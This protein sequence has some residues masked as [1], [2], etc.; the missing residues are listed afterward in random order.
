MKCLKWR[1]WREWWQ[2]HRLQITLIKLVYYVVLKLLKTF[3]QNNNKVG[4]RKMKYTLRNQLSIVRVSWISSKQKINSHSRKLWAMKRISKRAINFLTW[5]L[6]LYSNCSFQ[7]IFFFIFQVNRIASCTV[8]SIFSD[9]C[10][11]ECICQLGKTY[12][13]KWLV[14]LLDICKSN[15]QKSFEF[16]SLQ[17]LFSL[18]VRKRC[19]WGVLKRRHRHFIYQIYIIPRWFYCAHRIWH[20][21]TNRQMFIENLMQ[22]LRFAESNERKNGWKSFLS[23][24]SFVYSFFA[25]K[26]RREINVIT[27]IEHGERVLFLLLNVGNIMKVQQLQVVHLTFQSALM[28]T[29]KFQNKNKF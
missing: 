15:D 13:S 9:I 14:K 27:W 18:F 3:C 24:N 7:T 26:K 23:S 12:A 5:E 16:H 21:L 1:Q 29:F 25:L 17:V 20:N 28:R 6:K 22:I 8:I 10:I 2:R 19:S 11:I 4:I